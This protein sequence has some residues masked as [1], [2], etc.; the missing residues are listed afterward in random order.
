[1]LIT[2]IVENNGDRSITRGE[3]YLLKKCLCLLGIHIN[4]RV[5]LYDVKRKGIHASQKVESISSWTT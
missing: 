1:M 4:H 2:G 3:P 5:R